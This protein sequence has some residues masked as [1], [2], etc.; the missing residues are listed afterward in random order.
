MKF[1]TN[2]TIFTQNK[3]Y[4]IEP[5]SERHFIQ[6]VQQKKEVI[7]LI[8]DQGTVDLIALLTGILFPVSVYERPAKDGLPTSPGDEVVVIKVTGLSSGKLT[9][10]KLDKAELSFL[11]MYHCK[12]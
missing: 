10:E 8:E 4:Y 11:W 3:P 5:M 12:P 9:Q 1:I 7:S 6:Y 2:S